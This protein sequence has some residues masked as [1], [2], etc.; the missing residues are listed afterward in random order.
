MEVTQIEKKI[1]QIIKDPTLTYQ[2]RKHA[3]AAAAE[4]LLSPLLLSKNLRDA[5]GQGIICDMLEGAAPYRPRY[6]LPDYQK[7]LKQGCSFLELSP[8]STLE[9]AL[10]FLT[11]FYTHVPSITG[12]PVYLGDIDRLLSP[13]V[14]GRDKKSIYDALKPFWQS[15]DRLFHDSFV[16]ANIG[17]QESLVGT[18]ILQLERDLQQACPNLSLKYDP[19]QTSDAF[20]HESIQTV[21]KVGKPHIANHPLHR[22]ALGDEYGIASCYNTLKVG[23]GAHTMVRLNL[24]EIVHHHRPDLKTFMGRLLPDYIEHTLELL[25][26]RTKFLVD[27]TGFF[28]HHFLSKEGFIDISHFSSMFGIFGMAEAVNLLLEAKDPHELYGHSPRGQQLA[29]EI[30]ALIKTALGNRVIPYAKGNHGHAFLHAQSGIDLDVDATAGT[31][32]PYGDEPSLFEHIQ[33]VAPF[34]A[35]FDAGISD[36]FYFDKT[37]LQNPKAIMD[38]TKGAMAKGM[39]DFTFNLSDSDFIRITGFLVRRKDVDRAGKES[40]LSNSAILGK[41]S[42]EKRSKKPKAHTP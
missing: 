20:L 4:N 21:F 36:I 42:L 26:A 16:H 23:G 1:D 28:K 24:K 40:V 12:Y 11:V 2:Q 14:T 9:E 30:L 22:A 27:E 8:P 31:R 34:H 41:G 39:K 5:M 15:L 25:E 37:A 18:V 3:L 32:I 7:A 38:I 35:Y 6:I 17:P 33:F 29:L 10:S 19:H 13:Y